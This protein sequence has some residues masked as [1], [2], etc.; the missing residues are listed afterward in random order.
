MPSRRVR[1]HAPSSSRSPTQPPLIYRLHWP[2]RSPRGFMNRRFHLQHTLHG[3]IVN[4]A[5]EVIDAAIG[6][7]R[8]LQAPA[9]LF[10]NLRRRKSS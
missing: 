9:Q 2:H 3:L 5:A 4:A 7:L 8:S 1:R 6:L 10:V